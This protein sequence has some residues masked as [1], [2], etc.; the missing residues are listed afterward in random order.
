MCSPTIWAPAT[1]S[2]HHCTA[3][4]KCSWRENEL[5]LEWQ[6]FV[7]YKLKT[8]HLQAWVVEGGY[9]ASG[10][11][12]GGSR[13]ILGAGSWG[14][15]PDICL[16]PCSAWHASLSSPP[17]SFTTDLSPLETWPHLPQFAL[18]PQPANRAKI[19]PSWPKAW[20]SAG[21]ILWKGGEGAVNGGQVPGLFFYCSCLRA[22][23]SCRLRDVK[24]HL[25]IIQ[26]SMS[27]QV[28]VKWSLQCVCLWSLFTAT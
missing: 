15:W 8:G 10:A 23:S 2:H 19:P 7:E 4:S 16:P 5:N 25:I 26:H 18:P 28:N 21:R 20:E 24:P 17:P 27:N 13:R 1:Q 6:V 9:V 12:G 22:L 3:S 11:R 14:N